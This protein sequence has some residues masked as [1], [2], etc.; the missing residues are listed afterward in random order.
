MATSME[1][2]RLDDSLRYALVSGKRALEN[3]G[4]CGDN[5]IKVRSCAKVF[6]RC[7]GYSTSSLQNILLDFA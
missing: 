3:A 2:R 5:L 1:R 7:A 4:S 6:S